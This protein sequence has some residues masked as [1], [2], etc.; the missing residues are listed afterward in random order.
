MK[1][2]R[3]INMEAQRYFYLIT[4]S[5]SLARSRYVD[6]PTFLHFYKHLLKPRNRKQG[7]HDGD[8]KVI[9]IHEPL[10]TLS[11]EIMR[12]IKVSCNYTHALMT[13]L[14]FERVESGLFC[15]TLGDCDFD[16]ETDRELLQ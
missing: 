8:L 7:S 15:S 12:H 4:L 1:V 3:I 5:F 6:I 16:G 10:T 14:K 13:A 11:P 2:L 9:C